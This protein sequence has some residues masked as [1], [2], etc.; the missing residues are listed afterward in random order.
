MSATL[1]DLIRTQLDFLL[2]RPVRISV[3]TDF[4]RW[5]LYVLVISWLVGVGRYWDHPSAETWQYF[6][7]GSVA[8]IFCLSALLYVVVL[9]L[10]PSN[11]EYRGVLVFVGLTSLPAALYAIPVERF[12]DLETAK[13]M[14]AWFL[15]V[16]AAWRVALLLRYL[17]KSARL[18]W[19]VIVIVTVMLLSGIVVTLS[20]LNLEH[21]VFDIMAGIREENASPNDTAYEIVLMLGIFSVIAFP[22]TFI[23]YVAAVVRRIRKEPAD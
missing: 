10:R 15:G 22:V 8:Y 9:P 2:F 19:V 23:A 20:M 17:N 5:F 13:A 18:G 21:V 12:M 14:N 1:K 11:W 6:G 7:L 4:R 3:S 16:V